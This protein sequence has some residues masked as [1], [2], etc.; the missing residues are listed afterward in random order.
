MGAT[1]PSRY[2]KILIS[3]S[4]DTF[5]QIKICTDTAQRTI[6]TRT[7]SGLTFRPWVDNVSL[8]ME[9]LVEMNT[10]IWLLFQLM[11]SIGLPGFPEPFWPPLLLPVNIRETHLKKSHNDALE[12]RKYLL[13]KDRK[14]FRFLTQSTVVGTDT[15]RTFFSCQRL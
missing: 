12:K 2:H 3:N 15:N 8:S 13:D 7:F 9:Q 10:W 11:L 4:N 14:R 6:P 1:A 5:L